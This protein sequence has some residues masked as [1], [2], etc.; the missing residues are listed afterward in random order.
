MPDTRDHLYKYLLVM[1]LWKDKKTRTEEV[2]RGA[3]FQFVSLPE[4]KDKPKYLA[5]VHRR[6]VRSVCWWQWLMVSAAKIL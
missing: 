2:R 3:A 5:A 4:N 6:L 1:T